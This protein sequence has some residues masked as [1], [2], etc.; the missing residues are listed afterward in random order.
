MT[1]VDIWSMQNVVG[2]FNTGTGYDGK[3]L[4]MPVPRTARG[5]LRL[6][7]QFPQLLLP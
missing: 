3:G 7:L 1:I 5:S 2:S 4:T 6:L